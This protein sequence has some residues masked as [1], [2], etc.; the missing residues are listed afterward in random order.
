M[1]QCFFAAVFALALIKD[2]DVAQSVI[3][4]H[5]AHQQNKSENHLRR[6]QLKQYTLKQEADGDWDTKLVTSQETRLWANYMG[7]L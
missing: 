4:R 3:D 1:Q 5:I 2:P 7:G 6:F